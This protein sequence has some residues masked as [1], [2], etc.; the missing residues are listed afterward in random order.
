M[1]KQLTDFCLPRV[2]HH[3]VDDERFPQTAHIRNFNHNEE[4]QQYE[5]MAETMNNNQR[6]VFQIITE[7]IERSPVTAHF[8]L[9]GAGDTGKTYL[10][11]AL[12]SYYRSRL[13]RDQDNNDIQKFVVCVASTGIAGLL[14]PRGQMA[15]S[16]FAVPLDATLGSKLGA[17]SEQARLLRDTQLII[18]DEVPM[19]NKQVVEAVDKCLQNITQVNPLFGCIPVVLGGNWAQILP[20]VPR[21]S[22]GAI[23]NACLQRLYIW[24]S[25]QKVFL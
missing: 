6:A 21:G 15:H 4:G 12:C 5:G 2:I 14:L 3:W 22:R 18:W 9:E 8:F 1:N 24:P 10:Y 16:F 20:V 17:S 13:H 23:V 19:Q 7:A 25:L 11:R